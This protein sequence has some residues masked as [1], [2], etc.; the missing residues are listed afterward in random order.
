MKRILVGGLACIGALVVLLIVIAL[1]LGGLAW[2]RKG[3]V[4]AQTIL[5]VD[6]T[7]GLQEQARMIR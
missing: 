2:V 7:R 3:P 6:L 5:E 1:G 4:P